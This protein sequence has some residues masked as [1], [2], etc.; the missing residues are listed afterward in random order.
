MKNTGEYWR[1][2]LV[3][4]GVYAIL[5]ASESGLQTVSVCGAHDMDTPE[6]DT[7]ILF[8]EQCGHYLTEGGYLAIVTH[9]ENSENTRLLPTSPWTETK[10]K[11]YQ[12]YLRRQASRIRAQI[13]GIRD[14]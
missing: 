9:Q 12:A 10:R 4:T 8:I 6:Q 11:I 13:P 2:I 14:A 5:W 3:N 1:V 7:E